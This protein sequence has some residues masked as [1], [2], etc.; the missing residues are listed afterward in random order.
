MQLVNLH[1][2]VV[3]LHNDAVWALSAYRKG[4]GSSLTL[5]GAATQLNL[6]CAALGCE[7]LFL[8]APG[9]DLVSEGVD[10]ASRELADRLAG[11][12]CSQARNK[13]ILPIA[14]RHGWKLT[15][16]AFASFGNRVVECYSSE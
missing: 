13:M 5:Q 12:S 4:W 8:H 14:A 2:S 11:P 9:S 15:V 1:E 3:I 7:P 10:D 16:D 6:H